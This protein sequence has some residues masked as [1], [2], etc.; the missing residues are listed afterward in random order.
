MTDD[1]QHQT[2]KRRINIGEWDRDFINVDQEMLLQLILAA[3][4]LDIKNLL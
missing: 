1:S 4:Y 3:N 2:G